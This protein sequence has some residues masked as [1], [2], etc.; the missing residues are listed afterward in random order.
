ML[1][2]SNYNADA[3]EL[4]ELLGWKNLAR[5]QE[6]HKAIVM[7]RCLHGLAPEYLYSKFTWRDSSYDLRDSESKLNVPL[8]CTNYYRKSFG[9][10]GATLWNSLPC[11]IRNTDS[12]GVFKVTVHL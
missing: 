9:Y 3:T 12:L 2:F 8:P 10:N 1:I 5:Q 4:L 11:N 6:S 7:Y